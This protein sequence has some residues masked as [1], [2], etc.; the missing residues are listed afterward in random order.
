M[1]EQSL[2][3]KKLRTKLKRQIEEAVPDARIDYCLTCGMCVSGCPASGLEDMDPRKFLRL[4][5]LGQDEAILKTDWI[6]ACT[7][8]QRCE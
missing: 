4:L 5:V 1:Q 6:Y 8:C 3:L 7:M 2:D